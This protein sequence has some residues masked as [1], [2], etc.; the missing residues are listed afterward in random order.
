MNFA[1][2]SVFKQYKKI[3]PPSHQADQAYSDAHDDDAMLQQLQQL[4]HLIPT[5]VL[6]QIA[7]QQ[8]LL[9]AH[10]VGSKYYFSTSANSYFYSSFYK[11]WIALFFHLIL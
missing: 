2:S 9:M 5:D 1:R 8:N 11:L 3:I 10:N 7:H 6:Q 4:V